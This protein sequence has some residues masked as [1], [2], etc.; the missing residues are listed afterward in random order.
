MGVDMGLDAWI[1]TSKNGHTEE[2]AYWR[3]H[4]L[5]NSHMLHLYI[6]Q[7][8]DWVETD[9][10][11]GGRLFLTQEDIDKILVLIEDGEFDDEY[12]NEGDKGNDIETFRH[13][14]ELIN[15]NYVVYYFCSY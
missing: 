7:S 13:I 12:W 11:N 2:A 4:H 10:F 6:R 9:D 15:D 8:P 5:L 3:K 1:Y 14:K